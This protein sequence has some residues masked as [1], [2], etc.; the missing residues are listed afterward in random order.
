MTGGLQEQIT[1]GKE[2]F[3]IGLEPAAKALIGSQMVPYIYEDRV[4]E[5]QVVGALREVYNMSKEDRDKM[6]LLGSKHV[7]ENY[8]FDKFNKSWIDLI[9]SII[10]NHGSWDTRKGYKAWEIK[11]IA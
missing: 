10:E 4:S 11:E 9:D 8:N 6:G 3:G 1:D 7:Q 5:E 2:W